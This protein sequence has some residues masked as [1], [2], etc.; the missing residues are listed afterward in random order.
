MSTDPEH[1]PW[2]LVANCFLRIMQLLL[3]SLC[4]PLKRHILSMFWI[5]FTLFWH[6]RIKIRKHIV[7]YKI[8]NRT[9]SQP[10][11]LFH[12]CTVHRREMLRIKH[13]HQWLLTFVKQNIC[14]NAQM[15]VIGF[16]HRMPSD[17]GTHWYHIALSLQASLAFNLHL[18]FQASPGWCD[19]YSFY[20]TRSTCIFDGDYEVILFSLPLTT[21]LVLYKRHYFCLLERYC[22]W[23]VVSIVMTLCWFNRIQFSESHYHSSYS[24]CLGILCCYNWRLQIG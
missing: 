15:P 5:M 2:L 17:K 11:F 16:P 21:M 12:R 20:A 4:M 8:Q 19:L 10:E 9:W 7:D 6:Y 13:T 23:N 14:K 18:T 22:F 1:L 3:I 24:L